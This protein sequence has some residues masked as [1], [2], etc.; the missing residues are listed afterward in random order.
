[1]SIQKDKQQEINQKKFEKLSS[2]LKQNLQRRKSPAKIGKKAPS[3][4]GSEK[5]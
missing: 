2:T 5:N 4:R 3:E 1:M